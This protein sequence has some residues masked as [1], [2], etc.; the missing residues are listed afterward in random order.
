[1]SSVRDRV[2]GRHDGPLV[3]VTY[4]VEPARL[5]GSVTLS[6]AKNS[7]LR[8]L[9]ATLLTDEPVRLTNYPAE[10][11]DAQVHVDMLRALGKSVEVDVDDGSVLVEERTAPAQELRWSGRS[12]RNTLLILGALTARTGG[13]SVPLPGGCSIGERKYDL[14]VAILRS[15]GAEVWEEQGYL[16]AQATG[17]LRGADL[18]L[19][20]KSTGATENALLMG[21]L[22]SGVTRVYNPHVTPEI[23]DLANCLRTMG[24]TIHFVGRRCIEIHGAERLTAVTHTVIPDRMEAITW[25]I[26]AVV[27]G[28]Q[29]EIVNFPW[30]AVEVPLVHLRES[31]M[32][33]FRGDNSMIVRGHPSPIDIGTGSHPAVHSDMQPLFAVYGASSPGESLITDLRYPGR[34]A[35]V[36]QLKRFGV[37]AEMIGNLLRIQGGMTLRGAEVSAPDLRAGAALLLTALCADSP[38]V[39]R[40]AWQ[41]ERGYADVSRKLA[42]LGATVVRIDDD[43]VANAGRQAAVDIR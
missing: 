30:K 27:T 9:A 43:A 5:E 4:H 13:G 16:H 31:G 18:Y 36:E 6:G 29:I 28:G 35:Y 2:G 38:S 20:V 3:N 26:A 32:E 8:L 21:A 25:A 7:A 19:A 22:A 34:F 24:A 23:V 11:L 14:H 12:I 1:M 37:V 33:L 17:R 40:D 42:G 15:L 10:L 41:L 39:I